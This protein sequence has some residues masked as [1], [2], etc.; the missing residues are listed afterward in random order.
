MRVRANAKINLTLDIVGKRA[1]GYHLL[2]SVMQSVSL[3][4]I[5]T[6]EKNDS[7][8]V[9]CDNATISGENN[10]CYKAAVNFFG[11]TKLCGGAKIVI[12]KQIPLAAGMGG[13]SADAAAVICALNKIY[14]T[15]LSVSK[16]CEIALTVGADVPF[17]I[18]G[19]TARVQGIGEDIS[20]LRLYDDGV[21][22]FV[23]HGEKL[24]TADMYKKIDAMDKN[25]AT[26]QKA[27]E[28]IHRGNM[29]DFYKNI[30][31]DFSLVAHDD[32]LLKDIS[33]TNPRVASLSGSG[34]TVF[35]VYKNL[36][37]ANLAANMLI[38]NG[39]H[40]IIAEPAD[41]GIIFE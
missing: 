24:S 20:P 9:L 1:D 35:A 38:K 4:D 29:E 13:G 3:C 30:S 37:E 15:D 25:P 27:V 26:T 5:I 2:D 12:K 41:C 23:K 40:P 18:V 39:Y 19:G 36:R 6:V 22:L 21:F 8:T 17:C 14:Q 11:F 28:A 33:S 32:K 31:N 10:I 7:I 34:P 16:L